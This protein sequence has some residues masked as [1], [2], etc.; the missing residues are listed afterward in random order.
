MKRRDFIALIGGAAVGLPFIARAQQGAMPVIGFLNAA[1]A[2]DYA[3]LSAAFL[4][5]LGEAGYVDGRNVAIEYRWAEGRNDQLPGRRSGSASGGGDCRDHYAG[6]ARRQGGDL[7]HSDRV[8][9]GCGPGQA[10]SGR[11]PQ[12]TGRQ[13]HG[14]HPNQ[15]GARAETAGMPARAPSRGP[16]HGLVGQPQQSHRCR[17]RGEPDAGGGPHARA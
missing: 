17:G 3:R 4:K 1:A 11:Q 16:R 5:G 13:R 12:S 8:R 10:W 15:L 9:N 14:R 2:R 7:D 6:G